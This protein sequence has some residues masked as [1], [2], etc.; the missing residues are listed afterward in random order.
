ME[1]DASEFDLL[2]ELR[3]LMAQRDEAV[4]AFDVFA[5]NAAMAP[6]PDLE[7]GETSSNDA[8]EMAAEEVDTFR[9]QI[10]GLMA[11]ATDDEILVAYR[12]TGGEI[13]DLAAETL[14]DE[15]RRRNLSE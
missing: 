12:E 13:G 6:A 1:S 4:E 15:M 7:S 11:S 10:E 8:A 9:S 5:Q 14:L 2:G 3:A